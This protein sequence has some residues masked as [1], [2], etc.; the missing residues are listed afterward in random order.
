MQPH[1][2]DLMGFP[3]LEV[4]CL[5]YSSKLSALCILFKSSMFFSVNLI[6]SFTTYPFKARVIGLPMKLLVESHM[7]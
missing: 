1:W 6:D 4:H 5:G 3:P 2:S 7:A